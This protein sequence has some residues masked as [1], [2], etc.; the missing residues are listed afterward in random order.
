MSETEDNKYKVDWPLKLKLP[1]PVSS[2][3]DIVKKIGCSNDLKGRSELG[4]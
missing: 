4:D 2:S 1:L 3:I